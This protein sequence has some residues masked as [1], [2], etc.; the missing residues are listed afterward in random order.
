MVYNVIQPNHDKPKQTKLIIY[1]K[2]CCSDMNQVLK[3]QQVELRDYFVRSFYCHV[4]LKYLF[5]ESST[6]IFALLYL[7]IDL[8]NILFEQNEERDKLYLLS[9]MILRYGALNY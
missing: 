5:C 2:N 4:S 3:D 9:D 7:V 8:Y 6:L 1:H